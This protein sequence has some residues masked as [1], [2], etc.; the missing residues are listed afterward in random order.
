MSRRDDERGDRGPYGDPLAR[1]RPEEREQ[2]RRML[3]QVGH[4][5]RRAAAER[6]GGEKEGEEE[7][8]R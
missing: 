5:L 7:R 1:L 4:N 6:L 3:L 2:V 8:R